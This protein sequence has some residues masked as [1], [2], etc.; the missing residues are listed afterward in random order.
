M[1]CVIALLLAIVAAATSAATVDVAKSTITATFRQMNVP[2]D[3]HFSRFRGD[4]QFDAKQPNASRARIEIDTAS[5]DVGAAEYNDELRTR[6]WFD[7]ANHPKAVF[8]AARVRA[9]AGN[10][11]E[12]LGEFTLKGK[13]QPLT[14]PFTL[15]REGRTQIYEGAVTISRK[16][17][18]IGDAEWDDTL[19]DAVI[20]KFRIVNTEK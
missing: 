5:F 11:F 15:R 10:R 9:I 1:S 7:T 12:A 19:D 20:V 17:F 4:V 6:E 3:G 16:A 8:N 18:A 2:V 14:V 13:T